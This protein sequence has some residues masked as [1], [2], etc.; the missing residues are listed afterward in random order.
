LVSRRY[1]GG[2]CGRWI[3]CLGRVENTLGISKIMLDTCFGRCIMILS[4][5]EVIPDNP[6][7]DRR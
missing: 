5:R 7:L 1:R 3:R 6:S 2:Y 4:R